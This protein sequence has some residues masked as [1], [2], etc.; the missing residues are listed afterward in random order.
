M[1]NFID[2]GE[3][4]LFNASNTNTVLDVSGSAI[5][6]NNTNMEL[7]EPLKNNAQSWQIKNNTDGTTSITSRFMGRRFAPVDGSSTANVVLNP[8]NSSMANITWSIEETGNMINVGGENYPTYFIKYNNL[9]LY[10]ESSSRGAN[11]RMSTGESSQAQWAFVPIRQVNDKG[12]FEIRSVIDP[13][14]ALDVENHGNINGTNIQIYPG[15]GY[16]NQK[17]VIEK[18]AEDQYAIRCLGSGKYVDVDSAIA[19]NRQNIRIWEDNN[20]IAQRWK[21]YEYGMTKHDGLDCMIVS[22]GSYV[23]PNA[24]TYFMDVHAGNMQPFE[25]I[26]LFQNMEN[27]AQ[28]FLLQ[29]TEAEDTN[30][31]SPYD[32]GVTSTCHGTSKQLYG[33]T[34]DFMTPAWKCSSAWCS[35]AGYNHYQIRFRTREMSPT[36][37]VF[38]SWTDWSEWFIPATYSSGLNVWYEDEKIIEEFQWAE[39]KKKQLE[40]QVRSA[41]SEDLE[42]LHSAA[43]DEIID[44]YR[45]P[46]VNFTGIG[47]SPDGLVF[48]YTTDYKYGSTYLYIDEIIANG[49][50]ILR[51]PLEL[52]TNTTNTSYVIDREKIKT[53]IEDGTQLNIKYRVGYDQQKICDGTLS[54][55]QLL[56]Y[57]A[58]SVDVE[59]VLSKEGEHLYARVPHLGTERMWV[60][61]QGNIVECPLVDTLGTTYSIFEVLYSTTGDEFYI[62]TEARS[63]DGSQWGTDISKAH[64][65]YISYAFTEGTKTL[66]LRVFKDE[67]PVYSHSHD[68]IYQADILDSRKHATVS[69]SQTRTDD[70][71][72]YGV[73]VHDKRYGDE[74]T[75]EDFEELTGKHIIF[76]DI[77]GGIH[78]AAVI[79]VSISENY[80]YDEITVNMIEETI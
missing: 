23:T 16:N 48:G 77:Y 73:L 50:N 76:R 19:A 59:P 78:Y 60:Q 26:R 69:M 6:G 17:F 47:W 27:D 2:N 22:F 51:E 46:E 41:G 61:Y 63:S 4:Y 12:L 20:T 28:R 34:N 1:A 33:Y 36:S 55:I 62:Y 43:V 18:R 5:A 56:E 58:G 53:W 71:T 57:D 30:M 45:K 64:Y 49:K 80:G 14:M 40:I 66:F 44:I 8:T 31:P 32:V 75:P 35:E 54:T 29:P 3:Y 67:L 15:T 25:N 68:A 37:S 79:N 13:M 10:A 24:D 70:M 38:R 9:N 74:Q 39:A 52:W 21:I 11:V 42:L 65:K 72:A 7:W